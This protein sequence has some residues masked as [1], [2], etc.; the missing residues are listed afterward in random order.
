[1]TD[2]SPSKQSSDRTPTEL[3]DLTPR[4]VDGVEVFSSKPAQSLQR[5]VVDRDAKLRL[6]DNDPAAEQSVLSEVS[7]EVFAGDRPSLDAI[8]DQLHAAQEQNDEHPKPVR[9]KLVADQAGRIGFEEDLADGRALSEISQG[10]FNTRVETDRQIART[11]LPLN[12][13][14]VSV[15]GTNGWLYGFE[16]EFG[17]WFEMWTFFDG[18]QYQVALVSPAAESRSGQHDK[19]LFADGYLCLGSRGGMPT[20][21]AAYAKSVLWANGYSAYRLTGKFPFSINN[22]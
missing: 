10:T 15:A 19:H 12:S 21:E 20:L 4:L 6:V 11:R 17:E 3:I 5:I 1:M 13:R 16:D 2:T 8:R 18:T 22:R 7:T 9:Q 14:E